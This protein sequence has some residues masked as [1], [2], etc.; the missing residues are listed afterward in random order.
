MKK[1]NRKGFVLAETLVVTVFLMIIFTM[2]YQNF[3]PLMGEYERRE[4]YD[5]IDSTYSIYWLKKLIED[6]SYR[7]T[8]AEKKDFF[9][10]Y[11]YVR[12]ECRDI[13]DDNQRKTCISMV[14]S[15]EIEG[16]NENGN[17]CDI[18]ITDYKIGGEGSR[19]KD[20]ATIDDK[21]RTLKRYQ[22]E[23]DREQY[24]KKCLQDTCPKCE[25][26]GDEEE[27]EIKCTNKADKKVF[28]SGFQDYIKLL[29]DYTTPSLNNA[30]YRV[31]AVIHHHKD[32]NNYYTYSTIEV[33]KEQT[34]EEMAAIDENLYTL[35]YA[36]DPEN[37]CNP[38]VRII[39]GD[40]KQWNSEGPLC[41]PTRQG[42]RFKSWNTK[43]DGTGD[44]FTGAEIADKKMTIYAQWER[45]SITI[46]FKV[47]SGETIKTDNGK[48]FSSSGGFVTRNGEI[49]TITVPYG[50]SLG[51]DGLPNPKN[52]SFLY[53]GKDWSAPV[54]G[55][56][57][58]DENNKTFNQTD[59]YS[60]E[61]L[62]ENSNNSNGICTLN[63]SVNWRKS[64]VTLQ[65]KVN[66]GETIKTDTGENFSSSGGYVTKNGTRFTTTIPYDGSLGTGGLPHPRY[67]KYLY[68]NKTYSGVVSGAEWKSGVN[69]YNETSAYTAQQ[70][71]ST[72]KDGDCAIDLSVNW[73]KS[74][75]IIRYKVNSGETI[76]T[77]TGAGFNVADGY[78][79]KNGTRFTTTI[80]YDGSLGTDG[81]PNWHNSTYLHYTKAHKNAVY[82]NE[83]IATINGT[84]KK[85]SQRKVY[86]ASAFCNAT[87]ADCT[88]DLSVNWRV[89]QVTIKY[90]MNGGHINT[91][92]SQPTIS[93]ID[94]YVANNGKVVT[95]TV[96]YNETHNNNG[97][98][99]MDVWN[100]NFAYIS[101]ANKSIDHSGGNTWNTKANGKGT[102]FN[103][104]KTTYKASDFCNTANGDC[105]LV[106]YVRWL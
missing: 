60:S 44:T 64:Q 75:V 104:Y 45:S 91:K 15:L 47:N 82:D 52:A 77:D 7:I 90:N 103:Q 13:S 21:T 36:N 34:M 67:N 73:R 76:K 27:D 97:N 63:L 79:T 39:E 33:N 85:F 4:N 50:S 23:G 70:L 38:T 101:K 42:Y 98:G 37:S 71:C 93:S 29:P 53:Y 2:I 49:Y 80:P 54:T 10:H 95:H 88:V 61:E 66:S 26:G 92:Y 58:I 24:I 55:A 46:H 100:T 105:T 30:K 56:E 32:N 18:F 35:T 22:E 12:F 28:S 8:S 62:C 20:N 106:L 57:W 96:K 19:F 17:Y 94:G 69:T 59:A 78:V 51:S 83:W 81:L 41:V 99:L 16:C 1:L 40:G 84:T 25:I 43:S 89:A 72:L 65:Y 48:N 31:I 5:D 3:V 74:Q 14:K 6:P 86:T 87:N 102:T 68:Y 9:L 11:G